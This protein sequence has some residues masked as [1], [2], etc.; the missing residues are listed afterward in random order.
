[1][2]GLI[3]G[4]IKMNRKTLLVSTALLAVA[5]V[6]GM[7]LTVRIKAKNGGIP[8]NVKA[9]ER[10]NIEV[11]V[12]AK[13]VLEEIDKREIIIQTPLRVLD[14]QVKE[15][16]TV[17]KGQVLAVLESSRYA[18]ELEKAEHNLQA[19]QLEMDKFMKYIL[20]QKELACKTAQEAVTEA[21]KKLERAAL[22]YQE[23]AISLED[24]NTTRKELDNAK[25]ALLKAKNDLDSALLDLNHLESEISVCQLEVDEARDNMEKYG[26]YVKSPIDGTVTAVN[27][28]KGTL[29]PTSLP[30]FIVSDLS[31]LQIKV[32]ISEYDISKVKLGQ[33]VEIATDAIEGEVF[34][35]KISS[36]SPV[37][38]IS[39]V[40]QST[41]TVVGV[42]IDVLDSHP[43]LKPG[44]SCKVKIT[45]DKKQ[46]CLVVPFDA[47]ITE[48]SGAKVVFVVEEGIARR[49][50]IQTGIESDF[51]VEVLKGLKENE[52][53]IINPSP[54]IKDGTRVN[55]LPQ[56]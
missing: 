27:I 3:F 5:T 36:I 16:D 56:K 30:L 37:A 54:E 29:T 22:L 42:A 45:A 21:E 34:R 23:G 48:N 15:G 10:G 44:F 39:Q 50:E 41:E 25:N 26:P 12:T 17:K 33:E 31:A 9:V 51:T 11:Q 20:P 13:G 49:R 1:M 19:A 43:L 53:I 35:G 40:G 6:L 4:K 55:P 14:V 52:T 47:I 24:L 38:T 32:N 46:N 28:K 18:V 2:P 8:V 7:V